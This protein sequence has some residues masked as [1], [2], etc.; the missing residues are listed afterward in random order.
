MNLIRD[1]FIRISVQLIQFDILYGI[2]I[3]RLKLEKKAPPLSVTYI[4]LKGYDKEL[5][6]S[7]K[8]VAA[9]VR[10]L[11]ESEGGKAVRN[12]MAAVKEKAVEAV[13][14]G[15]PLEE[16][17]GKVLRDLRSTKKMISASER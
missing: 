11:M 4:V 7:A 2:V 5:V 3:F 13:A 14:E 8:E 17:L 1:F 10:Y 16:E 9:K 6:I 12:C 15:G